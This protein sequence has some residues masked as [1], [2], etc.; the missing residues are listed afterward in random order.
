MASASFAQNPVTWKLEFESKAAT[1]RLSAAIE[2]DWHLYALD[3][4]EGGPVATTIKVADGGP[5]EITGKIVSPR[6]IVKP[7]PLFTGP[8]GKPLE[9]KFFENAVSFELPVKAING[10]TADKLVLGVRYQVCNDTLCLPAKT[11]KVSLAGTEDPRRPSSNASLSNT[12]SSSNSTVNTANSPPPTDIWSFIWLAITFGAIS[13]LTPCVFPMIPI[14]VSYF[15]K[16]SDGDRARTIKLATVYSAGIIA[17]FSLLGM[18]LAVAFGAAGINLFAANPWVNL[19]IAAVFLFF[20]F[21]LFGFYEITIP[22]SVLT[23]LDKLTRAEEGKGS[24]YIGAL[25]M[26][27][28]FTLT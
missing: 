2:K 10:A 25:L 24:A 6:P 13:L 7:E 15:M 5:F 18:L 3:Q 19:A 8:D 21:N 28:T 16:H 22:S 11:V 20:A 26:G 4:P 17:T 12:N 27:L 9:T 1:A 14:T 23:K